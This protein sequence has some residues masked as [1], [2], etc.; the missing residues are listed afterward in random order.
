MA[1]DPL[2]H[3]SLRYIQPLPADEPDGEQEL[4]RV[5]EK[6][7]ADAELISAAIK[8]SGLSVRQFAN[9]QLVRAPRTVWRW[10]AGENALPA[11]VREKCVA[12]LSDKPGPLPGEGPTSGED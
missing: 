2:V 9:E 4:N 7:A 5:I 11:A 3:E 12:I 10:L 8:A 6:H 1:D